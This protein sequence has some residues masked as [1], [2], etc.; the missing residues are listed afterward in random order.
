MF[1]TNLLL[2]CLVVIEFCNLCIRV[3]KVC[4]PDDPPIDEDIR[5]KMYS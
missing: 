1:F 5:M 2:G 3:L 4:P